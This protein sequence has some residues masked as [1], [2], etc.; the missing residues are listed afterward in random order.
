[1]EIPASRQITKCGVHDAE[2]RGRYE[3]AEGVHRMAD[4]W[5]IVASHERVLYQTLRT[6]ADANRKKQ[7]A[8]KTAS[9]SRL[10]PCWQLLWGREEIRGGM[11]KMGRGV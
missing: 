3:R 7:Q 6:K 1:M 4:W 11:W 9:F 8:K 2:I 10:I 5:G